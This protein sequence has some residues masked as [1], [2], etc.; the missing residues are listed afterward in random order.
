[1]SGQLWFVTN[2]CKDKS[3]QNSLINL[4]ISKPYFQ[5][6]NSNLVYPLGILW[7][8]ILNAGFITES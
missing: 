7:I 6:M 1:M 2:N 3:T 5:Y 8:A 4:N